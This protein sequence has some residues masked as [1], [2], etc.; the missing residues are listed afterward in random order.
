M[1]EK[2]MKTWELYKIKWQTLETAG[3]TLKMD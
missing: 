3:T 1:S 2:Q